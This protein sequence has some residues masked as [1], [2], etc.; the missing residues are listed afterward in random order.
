MANIARRIL[1]FVPVV[2][3]FFAIYIFANQSI[4]ETSNDLKISVNFATG[5]KIVDSYL[6]K[7]RDN[8]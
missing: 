8:T 2:H 5:S 3:A 7:I 4:F 6:F 1:Y